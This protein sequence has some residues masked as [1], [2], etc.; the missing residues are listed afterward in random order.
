MAH[1]FGV[2]WA[3]A[4]GVPA[5]A[6]ASPRDPFEMGGGFSAESASA[7]PRSFEGA[8]YRTARRNAA[9][10]GRGALTAAVSRRRNKSKALYRSGEHSVA[11]IPPTILRG[12]DL[13]L[14]DEARPPCAA[15]ARR[16]S[17]CRRAKPMR[18]KGLADALLEA[19]SPATEHIL[20]DIGIP[21]IKDVPPIA[22]LR[23]GHP[24]ADENFTAE[25]R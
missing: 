18:P 6:T 16:R 25:L 2:A 21:A 12:A 8:R 3:I 1:C 11:Q 4:L 7:H 23:A 5:A 9:A 20:K 13:S 10:S 19:P 24:G 14:E 22:I 15:K 17:A